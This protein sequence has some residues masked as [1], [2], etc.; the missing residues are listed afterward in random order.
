MGV[1]T[2]DWVYTPKDMEQQSKNLTLKSK[3]VL[4]GLL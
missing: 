3:T 4:I 2:R 1:S